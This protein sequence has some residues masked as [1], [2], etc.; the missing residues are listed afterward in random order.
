M[1]K[2][3]NSV[4]ALFQMTNLKTISVAGW[5]RSLL[6]SVNAKTRRKL[7]PKGWGKRPD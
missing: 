2:N 5:A 1:E 6:K 3:K 7:A 4:V